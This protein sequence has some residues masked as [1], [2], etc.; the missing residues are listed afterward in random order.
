L[1]ILSDPAKAVTVASRLAE[2]ETA[3]DGVRR[4]GLIHLMMSLTVDVRDREAVAAF[5]RADA[6][7][8]ENPW[9]YCARQNGN[10]ALGHGEP[11]IKDLEYQLLL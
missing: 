7:A 10:Y 1:I 6:I 3:S 11:T 9:L 2:S 4:W 8:R 5:D